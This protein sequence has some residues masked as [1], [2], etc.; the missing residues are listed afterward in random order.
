MPD[1]KV[2]ITSVTS[3][4]DGKVFLKFSGESI[5]PST[6]LS[7]TLSYSS[8]LLT[9][10]DA[11][12]SGNASVIKN[13]SVIGS[14]GRLTL[15][16]SIAP[17]SNEFLVLGFS[18]VG[19]GTFSANIEKFAL[20]GTNVE[21]GAPAPVEFSLTAPVNLESL[22]LV[23]GTTLTFSADAG[24][25][26][27]FS[28]SVKVQPANGQI[29][30]YD[31]L[32]SREKWVYIPDPDFSGD[33]SFVMVASTASKQ[34]E[35]TYNVVVTE[36]L[37]KITGTA[38]ADTLLGTDSGDEI[39]GMDGNDVITSLGGDD[40]INGGSGRDLVKFSGSYS[41]ATVSLKEGKL[42]VSTVTNGSNTLSDVERVQFDDQGIAFD[43]DGNAGDVAKIL[44]VV[45]GAEA[46]HNKE[47]A[48]VGLSLIDTGTSFEDLALAAIHE[49]LGSNATNESVVN[50]IYSN[51]V[52]S[53]PS[54]NERDSFVGLL[55]RGEFTHK[56][57]GAMAANHELNVANIDLVGL[58]ETGLGYYIV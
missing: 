12:F 51:V 58:S 30:K 36:I 39:S 24:G 41:D 21:F 18:G 3:V 25:S 9:F 35:T 38:F 16:G 47:Y 54:A 17:N 53:L 10:D 56:S 49:V 1:S 34:V 29:R 45:L 31:D 2:S 14:T 15:N 42:L 13:A 37:Q 20:N 50:L 55:E 32:F 28:S 40:V 46:V 43:L 4:E 27:V 11:N 6:S 8:S 26:F 44:S 7:L 23:E 57:L 48:G 52:G 22:S 33:D 5:S 19:S